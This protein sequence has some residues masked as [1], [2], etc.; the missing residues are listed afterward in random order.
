MAKTRLFGIEAIRGCAATAV[1]LYHVARH[2]NGDGGASALLYVIQFG[3]AG[4]DVFFVL[5]GFIILF[6]HHR[7]IG[8]PMRAR[9]YLSR[10]FSRLMPIYWVALA[11]TVALTF[12]G[13]RV[14]PSWGRVLWSASLLPSIQDPVLDIAWTLQ[15]EMFFYAVFLVLIVNRVAGFVLMTI[16]LVG[17]AGVASGVVVLAGNA[18]INWVFNLQFFM[19]M[20]AAYALLHNAIRWPG[21]M[22]ATGLVAFAAAG[23]AENVGYLNGYAPHARLIYG[24]PAML[25]VG[26][27]AELDRRG[28]LRVAALPRML[29]AASYSIYLFQFVFIGV[30]WKALTL[31]GLADRAPVWLSYPVLAFAGIAGG[32]AMHRWVELPLLALTRGGRT[33]KGAPVLSS[34][35]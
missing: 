26:G 3:H 7:D 31:T 28:Q 18:G 10:R 20:A 8:Q 21:L 23:L 9:N 11:L 5:S 16:W 12:A 19:G 29:G 30:A 17:I 32:L 1:V 4:V 13:S 35:Q 24:I 6:V 22:L 34:A 25:I 2:L 14:L 27:V 33:R 15:H